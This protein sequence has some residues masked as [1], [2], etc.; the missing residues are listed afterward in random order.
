VRDP[1]PPTRHTESSEPP[2]AAGETFLSA[3]AKIRRRVVSA[4]YGLARNAEK[5]RGFV[6]NRACQNNKNVCYI[7]ELDRGWGTRIRT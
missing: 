6:T 7:N 2:N 3:T 4:T 1:R 5:T